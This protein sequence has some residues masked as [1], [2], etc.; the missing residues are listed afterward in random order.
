MNYQ[1]LMKIDESNLEAMWLSQASRYM[2]LVENSAEAQAQVDRLKDKEDVTLSTEAATIKSN[3]EKCGEKITEAA[4]SRAL[5]EREAVR[6]IKV[7]IIEAVKQA[8]VLKGAVTAMEHRKKAL[9]MLVMMQLAR[10]RSEPKLPDS[11]TAKEVK[12]NLGQKRRDNHNYRA[13][14][15]R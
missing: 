15:R 9:E 2:E 13:P 6:K 12:E 11:T 3:M 1:E 8:A 7:A 14:A 5:P 10:G 4:V